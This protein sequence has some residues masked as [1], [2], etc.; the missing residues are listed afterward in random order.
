MK[1]TAF[2]QAEEHQGQI[3][4]MKMSLKSRMSQRITDW[5]HWVVA[6]TILTNSLNVTCRM[7][8]VKVQPVRTIKLKKRKTPCLPRQKNCWV[9]AKC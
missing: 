6:R 4:S 7:K 2:L 3:K 9:K 5:N 8:K 1:V